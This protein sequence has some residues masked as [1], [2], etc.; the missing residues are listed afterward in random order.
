V[1]RAVKGGFSNGGAMA[2]DS[3]QPQ[4]LQRQRFQG[5]DD[6]SQCPDPLSWLIW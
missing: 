1:C 4:T 5:V 3:V 6:F 2:M